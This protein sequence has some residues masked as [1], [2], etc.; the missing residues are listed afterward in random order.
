MKGYLSVQETAD[1]WGV[2]IRWVNQYV[3]DGRVPGAERLG[4]AWAIPESG[5]NRY[6][7]WKIHEEIRGRLDGA[8]RIGDF[9]RH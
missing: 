3:K 9:D 6:D 4:R 1:K 5:I 2:S 8:V 7:K